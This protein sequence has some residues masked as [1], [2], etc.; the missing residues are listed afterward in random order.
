MCIAQDSKKRFLIISH[1]EVGSTFYFDIVIAKS[2][3]KALA[4]VRRV[5]RN[6][7]PDAMSVLSAK[8]VSTISS[9]MYFKP[10]KDIKKKFKENTIAKH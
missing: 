5:R 9:A 4:K 8:E 7:Q 1:L 10:S 2:H 3:L 6:I